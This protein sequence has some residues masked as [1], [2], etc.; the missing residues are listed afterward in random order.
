MSVASFERGLT[1]TE[2]VAMEVA[3]P[4]RFRPEIY[5]GGVIGGS[6]HGT[7]EVIVSFV[8]AQ[9]HGAEPFAGASHSIT[10]YTLARRHEFHNYQLCT[11]VRL[12]LQWPND[13]MRMTVEHKHAGRNASV[14]KFVGRLLS[15]PSATGINPRARFV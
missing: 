14:T 3:Y 15:T 9:P 1:C 4:I 2:Q 10:C 13:G 7:T 8:V 11:M 6:L 5:V 12:R